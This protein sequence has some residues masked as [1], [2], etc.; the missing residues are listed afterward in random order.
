MKYVYKAIFRYYLMDA[1][2]CTTSSY[3]LSKLFL[4]D[5]CREHSQNLMQFNVMKKFAFEAQSLTNVM[6]QAAFY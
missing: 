4:G 2:H 5:M 1:Y 3:F 6:G